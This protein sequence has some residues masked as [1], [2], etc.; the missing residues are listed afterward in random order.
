MA[1]P[2]L[3][4]VGFCAHYSKQGDWAF[5]YALKLC[6]KHEVQLDVFH[7]LEDP[8]DPMDNSAQN[9]SKEDQYKLVVERERELRLY[10][11]NLAGDYLEVGF[12][13]CEDN[14]W[15]ELHRCLLIQEFQILVL[16][17]ISPDTYFAG[18]PIE[19]FANSFV[20]PVILV[21][22]DRADQIHLNSQAHLISDQ[23]YLPADEWQKIDL[24]SA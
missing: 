23:L 13:L 7:F 12:R 16:G 21:G 17:Y 19:E 4:A 18:K 9:L 1:I 20:S 3:K 5:D 6:R 14:E 11:D 24:V 22:P 8:F 2:T 15:K 10:Y